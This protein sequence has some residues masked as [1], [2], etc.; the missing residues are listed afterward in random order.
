MSEN[1]VAVDNLLKIQVSFISIC[2]ME[3]SSLGFKSLLR[4][5]FINYCLSCKH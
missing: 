1:G 2:F 3:I 4:H 5:I